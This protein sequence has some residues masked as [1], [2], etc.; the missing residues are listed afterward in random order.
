ML[1]VIININCFQKSKRTSLHTAVGSGK[2]F[3]E[4]SGRTFKE[5]LGKTFKEGQER[6][7]RSQERHLRRS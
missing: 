6:C 4:D 1:K 3:E 5:G 2:T 7:L